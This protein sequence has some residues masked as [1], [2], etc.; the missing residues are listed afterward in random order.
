MLNL[1]FSPMACSLATRI[2]LYE[3]GA[4]ASY[5]LVDLKAKRTEDGA[6]FLRVNPMG[7]VPVLR[8]DDGLTLTENAAVLQHVAE[9]LPKAELAPAAGRERALL[10][11]WL[12]FV[13]TE[14]H[15]LVFAPLVDPNASKEAK[16]Y[17]RE[18]APKRLAV[19]ENH[20]ST[21][22]Y[23][24][25]RFS[26]ADAYLT[27]ILNWA[28]PFGVELAPYPALL[29]YHRSMLE[30]P[31]VK[32]AVAEEFALYQEEKARQAQSA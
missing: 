11:Q 8:T 1:Y 2:A 22:K 21:R 3:A 28:G 16:A 4:E 6:D 7:Q 20:L 27:T 18:Q 25:D 14:L 26:V 23:L 32:R 15:K 29:T 9:Q 13:S 31:S 30:R 5:T 10:Q 12:G 19:L 24:L 17:A